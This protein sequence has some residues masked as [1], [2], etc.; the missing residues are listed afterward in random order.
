MTSQVSLLAAESPVNGGL[1]G[2]LAF[3]LSLVT[4]FG[5]VFGAIFA[6]KGQKLQAE[7]IARPVGVTGFASWQM[8]KRGIYVEL[9]DAILQDS[10]VSPTKQLA[11]AAFVANK[12]MRDRL[13]NYMA[14][15]KLFKADDLRQ[16]IQ[17]LNAD[18]REPNAAT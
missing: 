12:S 5:A 14:Q 16:I 9:I 2:W 10:Q 6:F 8:H 17:D 4:L 15:D 13:L 7:V 11:N 1:G 18:V 3:V